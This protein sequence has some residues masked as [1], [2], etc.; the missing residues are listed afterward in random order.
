MADIR[1]RPI[2]R[3]ALAEVFKSREMIA[4]IENLS[5][6]VRET[7]PVA[8]DAAQATAN[9]AR[10]RAIAAQDDADRIDILLATLD[11]FVQMQRSERATIDTLRRRVEELELRLLAADRRHDTD[12]LRKQLEE[13]RSIV[14]GI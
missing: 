1:S 3:A 13:L 10:D 11:A 4:V 6:D 2:A 5:Q 8:A 9:D 14:L 7:L 12:G